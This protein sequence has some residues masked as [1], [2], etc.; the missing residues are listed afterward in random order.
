MRL[1][2]PRP[3]ESLQSQLRAGKAEDEGVW[4]EEEVVAVMPTAEDPS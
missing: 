2:I 4:E 3:P 1:Y